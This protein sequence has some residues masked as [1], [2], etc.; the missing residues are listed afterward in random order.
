[1]PW[2]WESNTEIEL[3]S[4]TTFWL[5]ESDAPT[6]PFIITPIAASMRLSAINPTVKLGNF[7]KAPAAAKIVLATA[8]PTIVVAG[9]AIKQPA[10]ASMVLSAVGPTIKYGSVAITPE[11]AS[12]VLSASLTVNLPPIIITPAPAV[13]VLHTRQG[14][15]IKT[16]GTLFTPEEAAIAVIWTPEEPLS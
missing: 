9:G 3:E 5:L 7:T 4:D 16:I 1:M 14:L 6:P 8:G 11:P 15:I 2:L 13:L 10:S 12:M